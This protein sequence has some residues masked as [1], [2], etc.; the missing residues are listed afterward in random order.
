M[1]AHGLDAAAEVDALRARAGES[2]SSASAR[3]E[4]APLLERAQDVLVG[5]GMDLL[6]QR[7]DLAADQA[8][9]RVGFEES[10][11]NAARRARQKASVSSRQ[12]G[13]S[14]RTTPSS[15]FGLMPVVAPL[16]AS[17]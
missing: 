17:R 4:R 7:Q 2:S 3:R 8:A 6:E 9:N 15:R 11:R 13:S 14:G 12:S 1:L 16:V 10:M 5:G